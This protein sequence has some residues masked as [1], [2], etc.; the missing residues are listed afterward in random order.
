MKEIHYESGKVREEWE[1]F[2]S[3]VNN[4]KDTINPNEN[5]HH[6]ISNSD[7]ISSTIIGHDHHHQTRSSNPRMQEM[8]QIPNDAYCFELLSLVL[9]LSGSN[10]GCSYLSKQNELF[11][12]ILT[13]LHTS[14]DRVK[15]QVLS[16]IRRVISCIKPEMLSQLFGIAELPNLN[17]IFTKM[18]RSLLYA[19]S[20]ISND[21]DDEQNSILF[22]FGVMD[23]FLVCIAKSLNVQT[24]I[25]GI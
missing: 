12:D 8:H 2:I 4:N 23:I 17:D 13:L 3:S 9:A 14:S 24:K 1:T 7:N 25:K 15:R 20:Q 21:Q 6:M 18:N 16:L 19:N 10:V 5:I 11:F 22:Q